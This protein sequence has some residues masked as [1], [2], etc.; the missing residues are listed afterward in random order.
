VDNALPGDLR[1][2][3]YNN[4]LVT[5]LQR[6]FDSDPPDFIYERASLY[7]TAGV[8]AARALNVPLLLELNAPLAVEQSAYRGIGL[9]ALAAQAEVWTLTQADAVLTVSA[10][11]RDH[12]ISL[13]IEPTK[14]HVIPNGIDPKSFCPG[15]PDPNL[16]ARLG[17]NAGPVLGF[18]GG[19]RP[20]HGVEALPL[21]LERLAPRHAGLQMVIAGDGQL[22]PELE[23]ALRD[24][25]L[26]NRVVFT[27]T[28]QHEEVPGI[29]RQFDV[30]LAPYSPLDH[31][32]YFS[33]LK[34][35]EYMACGA[36]VVAAQCGQ[37]PEVVREGE[38]GSLYPPGNLDSF[39]AACDRLL[40]D[41]SLRRTLGQAA[42]NFV[43]SHYTWDQNAHRI[44][45]L[46]RSL[47]AQRTRPN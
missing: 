35:F 37:I 45:E 39:T 32:F 12:V 25:T 42:A 17:L 15:K 2:I 34:V 14:V 9:G 24:R 29:I 46:A 21:L 4:E 43:R 16:R 5:E 41:P 22:R 47:I 30:A 33:P 23:R 10:S 13:G 27:G 38:T 6:R 44:G 28:V 19:L 40:N 31:A 26:S 36:A 18:V 3:L 8:T 7:G 1:R 11:L 20:W